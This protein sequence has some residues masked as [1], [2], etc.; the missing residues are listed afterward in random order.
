[1]RVVLDANVL[2]AALTKPGGSAGRLVGAWR[3]GR[4][5]VI[6]SAETLTEARLVLDARWLARLSSQEAIRDLLAELGSRSLK[7]NG[8]TIKGVRLKDKG[9]VRLVEAA[10]A[11]KADYL[12]TADRELLRLR[13]YAGT[14]IVTA[15]ELARVLVRVPESLGDSPV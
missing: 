4:F 5:D 15:G 2:I 12:V 8:G 10:A 13:G 9:D 3:Q 14:E 6:A 7:V 1:M 11:G